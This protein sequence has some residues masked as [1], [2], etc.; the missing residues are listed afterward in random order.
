MTSV[1]VCVVR[2][3]KNLQKFLNRNGFTLATVGAGSPG[4]ETSYFGPRTR[5]ALERFQA[6][7][8][9]PV[10]GVAD[11]QTRNRINSIESNALGKITAIDCV[12]PKN[13]VA[14]GN[15]SNKEI[16]GEII[17]SDQNEKDDDKST[18]GN[19]FTN[20]FRKIINFFKT[21]FGLN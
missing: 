5:T 14:T 17:Q 10:T 21:L 9:I 16:V 7:Y 4:Q 19:F 2:W 18:S 1:V 20:L 8:N 15:G 12:L 6:A 11:T 13:T 3:L